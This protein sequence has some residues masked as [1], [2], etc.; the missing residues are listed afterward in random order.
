MEKQVCLIC[1]Y[2]YDPDKGDTK[3]GIPAGTRFDKLPA[4]WVCPECGATKD[5]FEGETS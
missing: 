3:K 5:S 1:G 2:C 4:D